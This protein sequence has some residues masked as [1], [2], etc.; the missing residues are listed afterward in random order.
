MA[1]AVRVVVSGANARGKGGGGNGRGPHLES[2][3]LQDLLDGNILTII[4]ARDELCLE[5]DAEGAVSDDLAVGVGDVTE[6]AGL[7]VGG[8]DLDDLAGVVDGCRDRRAG[9][10]RLRGRSWR[11]GA[12]GG[13]GAGRGGDGGDG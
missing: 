9:D 10:P 12:A 2:L 1:T 5:D 6:L 13:A 4:R 3:V 7:S 11:D 8:L